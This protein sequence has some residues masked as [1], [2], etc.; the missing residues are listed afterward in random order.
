MQIT[1]AAETLAAAHL[2]N[3]Q[4]RNFEVA[5][6]DM[7]TVLQPAMHSSRRRPELHDKFWRYLSSS[8]T[9]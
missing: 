5:C 2:A 7:P 4:A 6:V 9:L 1:L 8:V 3:V